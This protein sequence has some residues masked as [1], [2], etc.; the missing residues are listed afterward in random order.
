MNRHNK[1]NYTHI[2]KYTGLFG[3]VQGL[4]ILVGVIRNK[5]IAVILGPEGMGLLSL[6]NSTTRLMGDSTNFGISMSA[7]KNISEAVDK[8]DE[9]T[10]RRNIAMVRMWSL[11][12]AALGTLLTILLSPW[13][14]KFTFSWDGHTLHFICLAPVVGLTSLTGAELAILKG[15]RQLRSLARISIYGMLA[16]LISSVPIYLLYGVSGIVP[17]LVLLAA[18]QMIITMAYSYRLYPLRIQWNRHLM[19]DGFSMIRLGVAFVTA[20]M[21]SSGA[22]FLIRSYL[23]NVSDIDTVG[24]YNAG[25]MMTMTYV[26]MVFSA[27]ETDYFPRLS[28]INHLGVTFNTTVNCQIEV[29]L[30]IVSPLLVAFMIGLPLL[31]P[32]LFSSKFMPMLG[33]MQI[34]IL[35]MYM[36]A[37]KLPVQYIPLAK[38]D[39]RSYLFLE[40]TYDVL[41]VVSVTYMFSL[42]SLRGAGIAILLTSITDL[43]VTY[44]YC[45]YRYGY[46]PSDNILRF[47]LLQIPFGIMAYGMTFVGNTLGYWV[48]GI[49]LVAVSAIISIRI[50]KKRV[51]S[52]G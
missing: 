33:M 20:G 30:L 11:L 32:L 28:G 50:L 18:I 51:Q 23:N 8:G 21:L 29:M 45:R 47:S 46:R 27:M 14:S 17:S 1:D 16:A 49:L 48:G 3:G 41:Y 4:G 19:S 35:A 5:F 2:L 22:D 52:A 10:I 15:L 12:T 24:L 44:V 7:V 39:S 6:F 40:G 34:I 43:V 42:F 9:Q 26:S 25:V 36:R 13:L 31:L 37:L 38:G